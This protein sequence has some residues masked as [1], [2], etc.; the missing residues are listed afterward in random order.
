VIAFGVARRAGEIAI[1]LAL[2]ATRGDV[3]RRVL[4]QALRMLAL[5][6]VIGTAMSLAAGRSAR[7]LLFELQPYDVPTLF[8]AAIGLTA[9]GAL[10]AYLPARRAARASPLEGLRA[11]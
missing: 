8:V 7:S 5:G 10:A 1:R 6:L 2:G 9:V 11:E 3:L 4:G